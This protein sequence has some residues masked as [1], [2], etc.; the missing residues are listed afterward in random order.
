MHTELQEMTAEPAWQAVAPT[1]AEKNRG[2]LYVG[3]LVAAVALVYANTLRNAFAMD[4]TL[5]YIV[6]NPQVIAPSLRNLFAPHAATNVFRPLTF[7]S[8]ALDW[9]VGG[10]R[11]FLFHL[12]NLLLHGGVSV[13]WY[14]LLRTALQAYRYGKAVALIAALLFAVHPIHT[15]AVASIT[16]RSELLAAGFL[17]GAWILHLRN[18]EV[19]SLLCLALALLSKESAVVFLPLVVV[20]DYAMG[21]W[22]SMGRYLRIAGVTLVYLLV[23]W[24]VQGA[25]FG[26]AYIGILDNPLASVP[27]GPRILN[28]LRVAWKYVAL[29]IYPATLSCDYSYNQIPLYTDWRRLLPAVIASAVALGGWVWAVGN[30]KS[31]VAL[32]G[33][34]YVAGF[35]ATANIVMPMG[36]IMGERL[37]YLP[38][39]GFCLLVALAWNWLQQRQRMLALVLIAAA[40]GVLGVRT[41]ARNADWKNSATLYAAAVLAVPN[42]AKMHQNVAL[43]DMDAGRLD[44]AR[45]ELD[46]ALRIYPTYPQAMAAYGLLESREG[47][48]QTAGRM[49]EEAYYSIPRDDPAYD[50]IAVDLATIYMQTDHLEGALQVLNGEIA[51]SPQNAR[52]WANRA[53][54]KYKRGALAEARNDAETALRLD[55]YNRQARNLLQLLNAPASVVSPH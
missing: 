54:I 10:G 47:N 21:R 28:A 11:P 42:S 3:A 30:R 48:Y 45:K 12:V 29:Q 38:S 40:I 46:T 41:V 32:A 4:D 19:G 16:G 15:E 35:A 14:V 22:K 7:S 2:R 13:L 1:S 53:V 18:R 55:S 43:A 51:K 44:L 36:T 8:F 25:H 26:P 31:A 37:A 49:M 50:E 39:A 52:A 23:L 6:H 20:G 9:K 27:A 24:K 33:G 34:I 5:L 17:L